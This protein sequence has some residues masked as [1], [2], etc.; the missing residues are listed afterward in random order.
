MPSCTTKKTRFAPGTKSHGPVTFTDEVFDVAYL[1]GLLGD[2]RAGIQKEKRRERELSD[3]NTRFRKFLKNLI[4]E[5]EEL[6]AE[7]DLVKNEIRKEKSR[8][9]RL[10]QYS[11][12]SNDYR[13]MGQNPDGFQHFL[14]ANHWIPHSPYPGNQAF[15]PAPYSQVSPSYMSH[16]G[17]LNP[18]PP[19]QPWSYGNGFQFPHLPSRSLPHQPPPNYIPNPHFPQAV[20]PAYMGFPN[21]QDYQGRMGV[22]HTDIDGS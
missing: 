10:K 2:V 14:P 3:K 11:N 13:S 19:Q 20:N 17:F 9:A 22:P 12:S 18:T 1:Q 4:L 5:E 16:G 21:P 7:I 15:T 6:L 8:S